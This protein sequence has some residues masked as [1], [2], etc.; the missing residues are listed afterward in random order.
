M[1][2]IAENRKKKTKK[3]KNKFQTDKVSISLGMRLPDDKWRCGSRRQNITSL[4]MNEWMAINAD[5]TIFD[6]I[7]ETRRMPIK[8]IK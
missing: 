6:G 5:T 8:A 1:I 4:K 2:T 7:G 3:W